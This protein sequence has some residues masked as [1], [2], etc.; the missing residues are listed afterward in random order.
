MGII[1]LLG[2][3]PW[4]TLG[5]CVLGIVFSALPDRKIGLIMNIAVGLAAMLPLFLGGG[6]I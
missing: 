1:P 6:V 5:L 3:S 2:W 4:F